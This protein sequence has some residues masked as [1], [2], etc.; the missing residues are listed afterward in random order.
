ME[1]GG[2]NGPAGRGLGGSRGQGLHWNDLSPVRGRPHGDRGGW[3]ALPPEAWTVSPWATGG[4]QTHREG[5]GPGLEAPGASSQGAPWAQTQALAVNVDT[6]S[7]A[8]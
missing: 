5:R 1:S 7:R 4:F 6:G 8:E 2:E 3:R